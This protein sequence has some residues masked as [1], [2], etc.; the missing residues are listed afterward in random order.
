[1]RPSLRPRAT[2][3]SRSV[4]TRCLVPTRRHVAFDPAGQL[5]GDAPTVDDRDRRSVDAVARVPGD[6]GDGR[7]EVGEHLERVVAEHVASGTG[8][9]HGLHQ[10]AVEHPLVAARDADRDGL[11]LVLDGVDRPRELLDGAGQ[12]VDEVVDERAPA[13]RPCPSR[14]GTPRP[15]G[16]TGRR[17]AGRR[18]VRRCSPRGGR[19]SGLAEAVDVA[20]RRDRRSRHGRGRA[21]RRPTARWRRHARSPPS[22]REAGGPRRRSPVP[23]RSR[24]GDRPSPTARSRAPG[25][26]AARGSRPPL[27]TGRRPRRR[28]RSASPCG[29]G[30]WR[31]PCRRRRRCCRRRPAAHTRISGSEDRSMCFLSSVTSQAIDL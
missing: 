19:R 1:M 29:R 25:R 17:G 28:S 14:P 27:D 7:V 13:N 22:P 18:A 11:G 9:E 8:V 30:R 3:T 2:S 10:R 31:S 4:A 26:P 23:P 21:R 24:R 12:R 15:A 5:A 6:L 20:G 16:P